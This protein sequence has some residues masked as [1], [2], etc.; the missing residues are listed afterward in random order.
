MSLAIR[1]MTTQEHSGSPCTSM[2]QEVQRSW[3]SSFFSH[4]WQT[5]R[6]FALY[7]SVAFRAIRREYS[8]S[9]GLEYLKR[10]RGVISQLVAISVK[11]KTFSSL[12]MSIRLSR[13]SVR[14]GAI[15]WRAFMT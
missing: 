9:L 13:M 8:L 3:P 10:V 15:F 5:V 7:A 4:N 6:S 2:V 11:E 14:S 12:E 1:G